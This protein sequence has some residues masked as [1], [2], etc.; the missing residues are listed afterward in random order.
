MGMPAIYVASSRNLQKWGADVGLTAHVYKVGVASGTPNEAV[1]TLNKDSFAGETDWR[2]VQ[3]AEAAGL[4][5]PV[6][7]DRVARKEKRVDP[8]HYPKLRGATGIIKVKLQN[9]Q[10]R[11]MVQ[12]M[13]GEGGSESEEH[14]T[15]KAKA[16]DVAAYLLQNALAP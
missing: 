8:G 5:E 1:E 12:Q 6:V 14:S 10:I 13:T 11:M 16:I 7:L 2:L 15:R 9:V 4:E 3:S